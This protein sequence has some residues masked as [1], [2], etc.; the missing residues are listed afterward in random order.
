MR[1]GTIATHRA[2]ADGGTVPGV[3]VYLVAILVAIAIV[4]LTHGRFDRLAR[5]RFARPWL[6][7]VGVG[8]QIA[9]EFVPIPRARVEDLGV[10]VLL[11][12]YVALLAFCISNIRM[13]GMELIALGIALN[14]VVIALNLGMPYRVADGLTR[15]TAVKHR[16]IRPGDVATVLADR[17]TVGP[18]FRVAISVGDIVLGIG[19]VELVYAGSRRRR[20]DRGRRGGSPPFE[21]TGEHPVVDLTDTGEID[22][23]TAEA[24]EAQAAEPARTRATRSSA[25]S[26][27]G[28]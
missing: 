18:P 21:M 11:A 8:L 3:L 6:F 17:I 24:E 22:V 2:A 23:R 19:I 14:A 16:P 9:L 27:R 4:P 20:V 26:T 5:I 13:R 25:S 7:V 15:E 1:V 10:A 28:S 12:S